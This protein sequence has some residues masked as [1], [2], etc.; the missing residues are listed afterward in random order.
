MNDEIK[1]PNHVA[2]ILD[3]N[4]RWARK[5]GMTPQEGHYHGFTNLENLA[6][7]IFSRGVKVLSVYAFST[8][9]FSRVK[10]EVDY[11]MN[12]FAVVFKRYFEKQNKK[13]IRI[14]FSGRRDP[15]PKK[16]LNMIDDITEKTKNNTG[17]IFNICV[18]Y[19]GRAEIVDTAK[20]LCQKV[21]SGE[22]S[23]DD[24][25]EDLFTTN[26][27]NCLPPVDLMIRTSGE[28]RLSNFLLWEN[29]YAEFYFPQVE[30]PDFDN[31]EFDIA[32]IEYNKRNRRFGGQ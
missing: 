31:K 15:L 28:L 21:T 5:R 17:A 11:L 29:A 14:V 32:L 9:N 13:N 30:F 19:G 10:E 2:I 24:I 22:I 27:Y 6:D 18:N 4:R 25:D 23:I 26:L 12:L 16:V 3:G 1:I 20:K 8:E 7:Y